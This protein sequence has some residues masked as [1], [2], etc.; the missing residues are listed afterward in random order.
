MNER[1]NECLHET[2]VLL[3]LIYSIDFHWLKLVYIRICVF[4]KNQY[5]IDKIVF[6]DV[7]PAWLVKHFDMKAENIATILS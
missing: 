3:P 5:K 6:I 4:S 2:D 7:P 1:C